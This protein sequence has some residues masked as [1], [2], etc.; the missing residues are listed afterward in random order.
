VSAYPLPE[1]A[2]VK[3]LLG[4]LFDGLTVKAGGKL[5]LSPKA[6]SYVGLYA[7]DDGQVAAFCGCDL[8]FAASSGAALSMLPPTAAKEAAKERQLTAVMLA[9]LHEVMNICTRLV[10]RDD[11]PHLKLREI[12]AIGALPETTATA[13]GGAKR[14]IDFEVGIGKYGSG[15]LAVLCV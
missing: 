1:A 7:S 3:D 15:L 13:L 10:L 8:A 9:N 2:H 5:D 11:S 4:M 6:L 12:C 14:R